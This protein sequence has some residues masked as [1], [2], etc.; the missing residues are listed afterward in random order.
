LGH[1]AA[2]Y[3]HVTAYTAVKQA[4]T[5]AAVMTAP[6]ERLVVMLYDGALRFL[7]QAAAAMRAGDRERARERSGRAEAIV[8]ELNVSLDLEHGEVPERLRDLYLFCKRHL[9]EAGIRQDPAAIEAV[10]R[11]LGELRDAW[12]TVAADTAAS[13]A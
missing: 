9:I 11:L 8:D 1:D 4:Y 3:R 12:E 2:D 5:E 7:A 6:P 13:R 10:S